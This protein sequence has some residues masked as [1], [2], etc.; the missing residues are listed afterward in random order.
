M[1]GKSAI[2]ALAVG[3]AAMLGASAARA[4]NDWALP[5]LGGAVGGYA[6]KSVLGSQQAKS[7][8]HQSY[9]A[10]PPPASTVPASSTASVEAR[11]EELDKLAAGGYITKQEYEQRRQA[12]LD[13]L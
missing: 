6:L 2:V 1:R 13:E 12:I 5:L 10:P 3:A 9:A 11:L 7:Q 4:H 8:P